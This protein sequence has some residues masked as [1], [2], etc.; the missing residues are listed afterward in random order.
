MEGKRDKYIDLPFFLETRNLQKE[1]GIVFTTYRY[2]QGGGGE[3][4]QEEHLALNLPHAIGTFFS[5]KRREGISY[6]GEGEKG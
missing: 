6:R 1:R 5:E 4:W 2:A 3:K